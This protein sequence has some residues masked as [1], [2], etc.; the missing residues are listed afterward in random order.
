MRLNHEVNYVVFDANKNKVVE[1]FTDYYE[2]CE[3]VDEHDPELYVIDVERERLVRLIE[4]SLKA[5][6][7]YV[8]SIH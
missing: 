1:I 4:R 6:T 8:R 7:E 5:S 2:A 3:F